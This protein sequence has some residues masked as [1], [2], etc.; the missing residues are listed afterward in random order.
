[1]TTSQEERAGRAGRRGRGGARG[2]GG[3]AETLP[4][5]VRV[6][7]RLSGRGLPPPLCEVGVERGIR[8]PGADGIPLVT[9][10]YVPLS[11]GPWPTLLV[12]SPYGRGFPY[13]TLLG[14][15]FAGQGFHVVVQSCRGTG[16]SGGEFE[17]ARDDAR[18]GQAAVAWL[19]EQDWFTG[20]L[21]TIGMSYLG[22]VQWALAADPPPELRAMAVLVGMHDLYGFL[23]SG[24]AFK[25]EDALTG[26]TA[27]IWNETGFG[28]FLLAAVRTQR[29]M[30]Q[31]GTRLPLIDAYPAV[32]GGRRVGWIDDWMTHPAAADPFWRG[33]RAPDDGLQVPVSLISGWYDVNLDQTLAQY[34]R[35]RAG[36][37][38]AR[39]LVGPWNHTAP[40]DKGWPVVFAE[41]L[42]FLGA[43]LG[44]A[45]A[46]P[47][48]ADAEA[49]RAVRVH[50]GGSCGQWRDL[51]G[52]PPPAAEQ[53]WYPG[54]DGMLGRDAPAGDA[55]SALR[56]DPGAPTPS[57]G[58]QQANSN[59]AG[60]KRN[61]ALEAR[62]DVLVF[63]SPPLDAAM[64]VAGPVSA[65]FR[66][67]GSTG[68]FDV[69]ARLCDV[70]PRGR[71][72]NVCHGLVR[73]AGA[74]GET[75]I[76]VAMSSA[77]YEFAGGHRLRLQVAGGAHPRFARNLGT[78]EP[79]AT[80][81][82]MVPVRTE[83]R[84]GPGSALLLPVSPPGAGTGAR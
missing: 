60:R 11:G 37:G 79:F 76:Q 28:R 77:A 50:V 71:S 29:R 84:H 3:R 10:H 81:T 64:T 78:G 12:R 32:L 54:R 74:D 31:T 58:G 52:W 9:D 15:M 62:P 14:A 24:G 68:N 8:V 4:A 73:V 65:R 5:H 61:D 1:M 63:T 30:G 20:V 83:L 43:H 40:F 56:Y 47:P 82:T 13:D 23:Y 41:A 46:R 80:A 75:D 51:P 44:G 42:A 57:V 21:G 48:G 53:A 49:G 22:W 35:L 2:R 69:F 38:E 18:D 59:L 16:G 17:P 39:L 67:R 72:W 66:V 26:G 27:A 36:G 55:V 33:L 34:E 25:L 19:R 6:M 7:R 45:G 70:D